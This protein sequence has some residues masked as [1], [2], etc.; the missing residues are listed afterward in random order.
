MPESYDHS[1][2]WIEMLPAGEGDCIFITIPGPDIRI[3]IDGG[4]KETY[5]NCLRERLLQLKC[6]NKPVDLLVVTHIDHDHIGGIIE[7][8]KENGSD[9]ES[10]IVKIKNIWHNSYRHLQIDKAGQTGD[11]EKQ[12]LETIVSGGASREEGTAKEGKKEISALQGTTLA[13]LILQGGYSWNRQ[14]GGRAV[15][16]RSEE[17]SLGP[18]CFVRVLLPGQR[19]LE[20]LAR[21]WKNELRRS[22]I[23]FQFSEDALFDDAYEY[24][25]RYLKSE[26]TAVKQQIAKEPETDNA[27]KSIEELAGKSYEPDQ[28]ET[29]RSSISLLIRGQEKQLLLPGDNIADRVLESLGDATMFDAVKLPHHGSVKNISD[30]FLK[31]LSIKRFLISTNSAKYGHPDLETLAKI[32][33]RKTDYKRQIYFNYRIGKVAEFETRLKGRKDLEL[34]YLRDGSRIVIQEE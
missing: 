25:C 24:Y 19:E 17:I 29:N 16:S 12:I 5:R 20:A 7:L 3:L 32:A 15:S 14:F 10:R 9:Q 22:R 31:K 27:E 21:S 4:P 26:T 8:L 33:S 30:A 11:A 23:T 13:A 2:L 1:G 28:S 34:L 6:E 18:E